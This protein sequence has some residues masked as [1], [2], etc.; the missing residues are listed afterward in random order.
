MVT[1]ELKSF[2]ALFPFEDFFSSRFDDDLLFA[3]N[4]S[5]LLDRERACDRFSI[6]DERRT[7]EHPLP[8][9]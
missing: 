9:R 7:G 3:R 6:Q 8:L 2:G 4:L 1:I 5:R